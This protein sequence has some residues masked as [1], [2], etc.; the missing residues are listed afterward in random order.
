MIDGCELI[1]IA[2]WLTIPLR[3][4]QVLSLL[5][6]KGPLIRGVA[7]DLAKYEMA[8]T[9]FNTALNQL[10]LKGMLR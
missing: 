3:Q 5:A 6:E 2:E 4:Q 10:I 9:S 8:H 1:F 7:I